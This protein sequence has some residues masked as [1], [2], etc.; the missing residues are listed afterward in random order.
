ML[1][2]V[3]V[4]VRGVGDGAV[5]VVIVTVVCTC[6]KAVTVTLTDS[7]RLEEETLKKDI[8]FIGS[9]Y[10][11]RVMLLILLIVSKNS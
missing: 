1:V 6:V 2:V 9:I 8:F 3:V 7:G 10:L 11:Q 5:V 4:V